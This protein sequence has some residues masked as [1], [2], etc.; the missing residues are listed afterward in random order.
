MKVMG[1][2]DKGHGGF[3]EGRFTGFV[4]ITAWHKACSY[5]VPLSFKVIDTCLL[6][7]VPTERQQVLVGWTGRHCKRW[8]RLS[9]TWAHD[10]NKTKH[11]FNCFMEIGLSVFD[12]ILWFHPF[13]L[14]LFVF[15]F[16]VYLFEL[17]CI[18]IQLMTVVSSKHSRACFHLFL[19]WCSRRH[20][21]QTCLL[22]FGK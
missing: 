9:L 20:A 13:S 15:L 1:L 21:S 7:R 12:G 8:K 11:T 3:Q 17:I 4:Y 6:N 22:C 19:V 18:Y 2:A 16:I 14:Y 5:C 10:K